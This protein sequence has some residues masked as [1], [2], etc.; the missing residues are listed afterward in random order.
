MEDPQLCIDAYAGEHAL[1][2]EV[3]SDLIPFVE[4]NFMENLVASIF[5]AET[6]FAPGG[7]VDVRP[8]I[9]DIT[10]TADMQVDDIMNDV[11]EQAIRHLEYVKAHT[12]DWLYVTPSRPMSPLDYAVIMRGGAFYMDLALEPE[13]AVSFMEK[14]ADVTIKT[15]HCFKEIIGQPLEECLTPRGLVFPG[16]R[17]TGDAI[18]NLSPA[19]IEDIMCPLFGKFK[20]EFGRVMLH[21]CCTPAPS[22][23]VA[24]ALAKGGVIDCIDNWQGYQTFFNGDELQTQL[25]VCTDVDKELILNGTLFHDPFFCLKDRPLTVSTR[26][27][28]V[29]EGKRLVERFWELCAASR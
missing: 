16:I 8:F 29:E 7:L 2:H 15:I 28:S 27:D 9:S 1:S 23:H 14:I 26:A 13:L 18:V 10:E 22:Q 17:L 5:G 24:G 20:K 4:S 11:M 21:Y 3:G 25:G 19:M 6:H 12:P